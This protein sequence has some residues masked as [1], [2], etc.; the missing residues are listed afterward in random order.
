MFQ[1]SA[2]AFERECDSWMGCQ[3]SKRLASLGAN[4]VSMF[5][6]EMTSKNDFMCDCP[7]RGQALS[8]IKQF[9]YI[10]K[11]LYSAM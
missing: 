9:K 8:K 10:M 3:K 6:E 4:G 2:T 1:L 7:L 11:Q 5:S